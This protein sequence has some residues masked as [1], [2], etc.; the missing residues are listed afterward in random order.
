MSLASSAACERRDAETRLEAGQRYDVGPKGEP[1]RQLASLGKHWNP[2][3]SFGWA[4]TD[5]D[6]H[7]TC[8]GEEVLIK[9]SWPLQIDQLRLRNAL[10]KV[11]TRRFVRLKVITLP[12]AYAS[13]RFAPSLST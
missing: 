12:E 13:S 1:Q 8:S 7:E 4:L 5:R 3:V 2:E 6:P 11:L 9:K 10:R